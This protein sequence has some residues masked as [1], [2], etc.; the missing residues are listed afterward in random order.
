MLRTIR[1]VALFINKVRLSHRSF[2][3]VIA[4]NT[5]L[6]ESNRYWMTSIGSNKAYIRSIV[7]IMFKIMGMAIRTRRLNNLS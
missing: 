3:A 6:F 2:T 5:L 7:I 1:D 4:E